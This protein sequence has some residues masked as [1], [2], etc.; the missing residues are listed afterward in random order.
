MIAKNILRDLYRTTATKESYLAVVTRVPQSF[1]IRSARLSGNILIVYDGKASK[2]THDG[3]G[4]GLL[5]DWDMAIHMDDLDEP[6]RQAERTGTW[7]FMSIALLSERGKKHESQDDFET[8]VYVMLYHGLHY[9][10]HNEVRPAFG[11]SLPPSSMLAWML[12][13]GNGAEA[14][15]R[16]LWRKDVLSMDGWPSNDHAKYQL[17]PTGHKRSRQD[18]DQ[19][20]Q[21][22]HKSGH[23]TLVTAS[24]NTAT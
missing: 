15:Q 24:G 14:S 19:P 21:K 10:P 22:R 12:G 20:A 11:T 18:G 5:N 13:M 3:G 6:T 2:D 23:S 4:R 9:L 16:P 1:H 8:F 17:E 7:Q